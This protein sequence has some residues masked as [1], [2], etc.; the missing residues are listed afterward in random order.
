MNG[1]DGLRLS[2]RALGGRLGA[3]WERERRD[4]LFLMLPVFVAVLPHFGWMPWWVGAGFVLLFAWRLGLLFSG[5][6]LPRASVRWAGAIA[7]TAA[8]WAHYQTLVGREPGVA[9]LILFLGLKLMEMRARRDLF[10]VIFL[11]LFLLLAAFLHSQSMGTAAI[12]GLGLAGLLAAMLTMQ[13][14]RQEAP[15][16]QRLKWVGILLLQALPVAAVL[17]VLFPRPAG[18]LW[19]M[20]SDASRASTGL[21][22]T[23]TP[24]AISDLGESTA[25]AFRVRFE[26]ETP[27]T[28]QLYWRGPVFG[29]FDGATWRA[30]RNPVV[31]PPPPQVRYSRE[32]RIAYEITQEPSSRPWMFPLEMPIEVDPPPGLRV[33]LNPDLQLLASAP[34]DS[35][36]R[37]RVESSTAW[38]A[39]LN[40]SRNSLQNW[41]ELP[42]GFNPRTLALAAQWRAEFLAVDS[43]GGRTPERREGSVPT[44]DRG[45][46]DLRLVERALA[47][48]RQ[49]AFRY[50]LQ[51]PLLGRHSVDDFLFETR[52]GFCEHFAGAFVVLMRALD[53]P[54]RVVTGYQGGERNPVDGWWLV[55]QA[56]AHAWAEVWLEGQGWTRVDPTAAVAP[57]RI[58]RGLRLEPGFAGM[59][60]LDMARPLLSTLRFRLDALTNAWNQWLL[61]YDRGR[62]VR[63]LERLGL[64]A[65]DWRSIAGLLALSLTAIVGAIA[66]LTLHPRRARDPVERAW[67]DFCQKLAVTGLARQPHETATAYLARV[68]RLVEPDRVA[69][70]RRIAALYNRLRYGGGG[71]ADPAPREDVRHLLQCV[72]QFRP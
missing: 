45:Q 67:D 51:P 61:S 37:Y 63:L 43:T 72:R 49:Q 19:G 55:R 6:W 22:E 5:R 38:Q 3:Q 56:D 46:G 29:D 16:R 65:D 57:D 13:Y 35:R 32:A 31:P 50:T 40:E 1:A 54:A 53:I 2:L 60:G 59:P 48:F 47:M 39:G 15:I 26:G 58:E 12:V 20:Q 4:T 41:L 66:V 68:E 10:V 25:I 7:A 42:A 14:Q 27:P 23:M 33:T 28:A 8:V 70:A 36:A 18:T 34:L 44:I 30:L 17:F 62:Q 11:S 64:K 52:A 9:L 71:R 21:S 24:G 69:D